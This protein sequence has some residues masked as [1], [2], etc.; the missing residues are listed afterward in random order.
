MAADER[1]EEVTPASI[2]DQINAHDEGDAGPDPEAD[3]APIDDASGRVPR[4]G[5]VPTILT[6]VLIGLLAASALLWWQGREQLD[7]APVAVAKEEAAN[8]FSLDHR[9]AQEDVDR[10]LSLATGD[11]KKEYASKADEIVDGVVAKKLVVTAGVPREGAGIEYL[12]ESSARVLVA[13][14]VSTTNSSGEREDNRYRTRVK[15]EL[16]DD[17]WLVS[18]LEQVG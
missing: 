12:D 2:K 10:V 18:G 4:E 11:F 13:V 8:F 7:P 3:E 9:S 15:L 14:D 6:V 5:V 16:V 1:G 17:V